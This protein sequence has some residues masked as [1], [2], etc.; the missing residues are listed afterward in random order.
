MI[1]INKFK[2]NIF[3]E[4]IPQ[5]D[6]YFPDIE[7]EKKKQFIINDGIE[8]LKKNLIYTLINKFNLMNIKF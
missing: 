8:T 2:K 6:M 3:L 4:L 1:L 7:E 5:I